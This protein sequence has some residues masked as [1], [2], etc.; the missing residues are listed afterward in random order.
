MAE[1]CFVQMLEDP[2]LQGLHLGLDPQN[3]FSLRQE[4]FPCCQGKG[5]RY[6]KEQNAQRLCPLRKRQK[7]VGELWRVFQK[8][9]PGHHFPLISQ[10]LRGRVFSEAVSSIKGAAPQAGFLQG[11]ENQPGTIWWLALVLA[12]RFGVQVHVIS[13]KATYGQV[14]PVLEASSGLQAILLEQVV[15]LT[16]DFRY[17]R[18]AAGIQYAYKTNA[19][20]WLEMCGESIDQA[21][22]SLTARRYRE[23]LSG[24]RGGTPMEQM[25]RFL[26][27]DCYAQL[28]DLHKNPRYVADF[29]G[30]DGLVP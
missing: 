30:R 26:E 12:W 27:P 18:I 15:R 28:E 25:K 1:R 23:R 8:I 6:D 22:L 11:K 14:L 2:R 10:A 13:P 19:F 3:E 5:M 20:L 4:F 21:R 16:H 9:W 17:D 29:G 7:Q 24:S